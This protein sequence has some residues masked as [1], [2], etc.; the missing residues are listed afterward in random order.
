[1]IEDPGDDDVETQNVFQDDLNRAYTGSQVKIWYL[2][3]WFFTNLLMYYLY[4]GGMP[5]MYPL[6]AIFFCVSYLNYKWLFFYW[7]QTSHGFNED[8]ALNTLGI[9]K[10]ALLGHLLM[11]LFEYTNKRILSPVG[12]S[13][14]DHFRPKDGGVN[15]FLRRRFSSP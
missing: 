6:G 5:L 7:Y 8:V 12:Y 15:A 3:A 14:E 13:P 10:W 9:M 11:S 1:M 4:G 2:Y